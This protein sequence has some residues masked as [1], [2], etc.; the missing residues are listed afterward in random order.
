MSFWILLHHFEAGT[1]IHDL[2]FFPNGK[3]LL[4]TLVATPTELLKHIRYT[5][6]GFM[7]YQGMELFVK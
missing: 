1:I 3:I 4:H 7:Q 6:E 2:Y 5:D